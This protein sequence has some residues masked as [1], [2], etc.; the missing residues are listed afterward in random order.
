M[1][2]LSC[3]DHTIGA[4]RRNNKYYVFDPY[5][6]EGEAKEIDDIKSFKQE[7]MKCLFTNIDLP[8]KKLAIQINITQGPI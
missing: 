3:P 5:Y 4:Y 2:C 8:T 6:D 7:I 1:I